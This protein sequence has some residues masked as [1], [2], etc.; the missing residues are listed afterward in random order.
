MFAKRVFELDREEHNQVLE[1][2]FRA[3]DTFETTDAFK[4]KFKRVLAWLIE[5]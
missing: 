2:S 4:E 1:K 3:F 5:E